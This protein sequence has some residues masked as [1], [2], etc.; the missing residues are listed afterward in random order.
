MMAGP[1]F[2]KLLR[3]ILGRLI[4]LGQ[5]LAISGK[6]LTRHNYLLIHDLTT[7]SHDKHPTRRKSNSVN[8]NYYC[9]I[10]A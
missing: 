2:W 7:T 4:I 3:K 5:C 6:T 10:T 1:T 9:V 8:Y